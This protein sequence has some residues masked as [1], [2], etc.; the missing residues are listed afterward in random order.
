MEIR[1][2]CTDRAMPVI[3][4]ERTI[5]GYAVVFNKESRIMF[6]P[7]T[8][9]FFIEIIRPSAV[10]DADF[11]N[12]DI[13]ALMEHDKYR[14][15]ARSFNGSGTLSLSVDEYGVKYRFD[16]PKTVE[17]DNAVELIRRRDIF[18]SSFAYTANE[19]TGVIYTKRNDGLLLRE[20]N[21]FDRMFDVSPVSDPAYFGTDVNVRS[22]EE[23]FEEPKP[24]ESYKN[25]IQELRGLIN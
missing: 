16:A 2:F 22:L 25:E 18:G 6:D 23:L 21:K 11:R 3:V 19:K 8:K 9:R 10:T 24:D 17:G 4:N 12:W 14:L 5:E 20:V 13:K 7:Q 15:L 1:S